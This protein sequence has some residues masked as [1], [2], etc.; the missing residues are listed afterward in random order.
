MIIVTVDS[1]NLP[2]ELKSDPSISEMAERIISRVKRLVFIELKIKEGDLSE[3]SQAYRDF[4]DIIRLET[5]SRVMYTGAPTL[6]GENTP[7]FGGRFYSSDAWMLWSQYFDP[8]LFA[9]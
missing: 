3:D 2:D 5:E 7:P 8:F 1:L 6:A 9:E 4:A